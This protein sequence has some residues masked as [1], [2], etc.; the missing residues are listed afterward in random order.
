MRG[1]SISSSMTSGGLA[2]RSRISR[3]STPSLAAITVQPLPRTRL[4]S[5]RRT[6]TES[7][8]IRTWRGRADSTEDPAAGVTD[9]PGPE[10]ARSEGFTIIA[11]LP[12]PMSVAPM[13]PS[14]RRRRV[15]M[16]FTTT[17]RAS[18]RRS[19]MSAS[20]RS[21]SATISTVPGSGEDRTAVRQRFE[22]R[23]A[24][25]QMKVM[26]C[27]G[28][29]CRMNRESPEL[30]SGKVRQIELLPILHVESEPGLGK[31]GRCHFTQRFR[32]GAVLQIE[33]GSIRS[34]DDVY[35]VPWR[36]RHALLAGQDF[37]VFRF[38]DAHG[39]KAV[40]TDFA[41]DIVFLI[42]VTQQPLRGGLSTL[43]A[44]CKLDIS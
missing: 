39:S 13:T 15:P 19:T 26:K 27:A 4:V 5:T 16:V 22:L 11:T 21:P 25:D 8:T 18:T 12:S 6:L 10:G 40:V 20:C 43:P 2:A 7:S 14:T 42:H 44:N 37:R 35:L 31:A 36:L 23:P 41:L 30:S 17:S 24:D 9:C 33:G 28:G 34:Y 32:C 29:A 38:R 3:A 1:I